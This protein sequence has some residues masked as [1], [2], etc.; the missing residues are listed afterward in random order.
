MADLLEFPEGGY[1]FLPGVAPY[2]AGVAASPGFEIVHVRFSTPL[3]IEEGF[4]RIRA[5]LGSIGRPPAAFCA[6]ELRSPKPFTEAGFAEFNERY[7][8]VLENWGL[9]RSGLNPV[10]RSNVC[11]EVEKHAEP[12]FYAFSFTVPGAGRGFVVAGCGEAPEGKGN[13]RDHIVRRGDLT[14]EGLRAKAA[15]VLGE[16]ERRLRG[17]GVDWKDVTATQLYTVH[18][19]FPWIGDLLMSRGAMRGGLTWH[20]TRPPVVDI[21]FEMDCRGVTRELGPL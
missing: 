17:L 14:Q 9:V 15:W 7:V 8:G 3:A 6:C 2:S 1:R 19:V 16:Q 21:D 10:A 12:V 11:P 18:P 13:Y 5:H 4:R 20:Y